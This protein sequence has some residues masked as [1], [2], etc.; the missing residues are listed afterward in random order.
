MVQ[1]RCTLELMTGAAYTAG[2]TPSM[3]KSIFSVRVIYAIIQ[4][5]QLEPYIRPEPD[6][7]LLW[8]P[9]FL[10]VFYNRGGFR[11]GK[12]QFPSFSI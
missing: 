7:F 4:T 11:E 6:N 5:K 9:Q 3:Q 12:V 10:D 2:K 1:Y 8:S